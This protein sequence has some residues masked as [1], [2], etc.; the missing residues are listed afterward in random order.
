VRITLNQ[1]KE[2]ALEKRKALSLSNAPNLIDAF[3]Q[4]YTPQE[5]LLQAGYCQRG[6]SFRHPDS[7]TGNYSATVK[8]KRVHALS[9][10]DP[11]YSAGQ[12][13]HDAFSTFCTLV[14]DNNAALINNRKRL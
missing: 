1:A 11:L 13:A 14:C 3:N 10:N 5:F 2:R 7:E 8:D 6:D 9:S 4:A 12:G